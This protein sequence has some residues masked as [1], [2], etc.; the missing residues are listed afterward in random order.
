MFGGWRALIIVSL[1]ISRCGRGREPHDVW[2][3][4]QVFSSS[5]QQKWKHGSY[6]AWKWLV[7]NE[8][9][10]K[11]MKWVNYSD[12]ATNQRRHLRWNREMA[13]ATG[14]QTQDTWL[15]Q[16]VLHHW[17]TTTRQ[18][19]QSSICA[20]QVVLKCLSCTPG[21]HSVYVVSWVQFWLLAFSLFSVLPHNSSGLFISSVWQDNLSIAQDNS[22]N[23]HQ[24]LCNRSVGQSIWYFYQLIYYNSRAILVL[25]WPITVAFVRETS[26]NL[27]YMLFAL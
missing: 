15:V 3:K 18:P 12:P 11:K 5:L 10:M 7:Q 16:P 27:Y 23:N 8:T 13:G 1:L 21:S 4:N 17:A 14:N 19:S 24:L 9:K 2:W 26:H 6:I 22:T 20:A 25:V